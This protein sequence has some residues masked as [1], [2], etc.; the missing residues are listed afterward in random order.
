MDVRVSVIDV[1][2]L[3]PSSSSCGGRNVA[4]LSSLR[5]QVGGRAPRHARARA[6][7]APRTCITLIKLYY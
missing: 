2:V 4:V 5:V 7:R 6:A 1:A 3:R